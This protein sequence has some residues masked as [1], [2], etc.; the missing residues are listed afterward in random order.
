MIF[1]Y[2]LNLE[3]DS[4]DSF[5]LLVT[6]GA[7][8]HHWL[9]LI[10]G[11]SGACLWTDVS[12][13]CAKPEHLLRTLR[14]LRLTLQ[15]S[16][17]L[18]IDLQLRF[19]I[20]PCDSEQMA[21][22]RSITALA[23]P[24]LQRCRRLS[25]RDFVTFRSLLPLRGRFEHLR[26]LELDLFPYDDST[27]DSEDPFPTLFD[28]AVFPALKTLHLLD[29]AV[30]RMD[31]I[32]MQ[33]NNH[34]PI[35]CCEQLVVDLSDCAPGIVVELLRGFPQLKSLEVWHSHEAEEDAVLGMALDPQCVVALPFLTTLQ[36]YDT[37][38]ILLPLITAPVLASI[39]FSDISWDSTTHIYFSPT[40]HP[41]L[42]SVAFQCMGGGHEDPSDF[43]L[44]R[45][46]ASRGSIRAIRY[47]DGTENIARSLANLIAYVHDAGQTS[48]DSDNQAIG[49]NEEPLVFLLV[50]WVSVGV[51]AEDTEDQRDGDE[52][53]LDGEDLR[54]LIHLETLSII[55]KAR[56]QVYGPGFRIQISDLFLP[57]HVR[58]RLAHI[59][60]RF[61][62]FLEIAPPETM[63]WD[64][65][66]NASVR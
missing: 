8:C 66:I 14:R 39:F 22:A 38:S 2:K 62:E 26:K 61:P 1:Q 35:S 52:Q 13:Y 51:G 49:H 25:I 45:L 34:S 7:V 17:S 28:H 20:T 10:N 16:R 64:E 24:E 3:S 36:L 47:H 41:T 57:R 5:S 58:P 63:T 37:N 59:V 50:P 40:N 55:R 29:L 30:L 32:Q 9:E 11:T 43:S 42:E 46:I 6:L 48:N 19:D 12:V 44:S 18:P 53:D 27:S 4:S 23:G 33:L 31:D 65:T 60:S 21:T 15:R 56:E 54:L